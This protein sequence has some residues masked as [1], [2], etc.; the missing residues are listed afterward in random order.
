MRC[1]SALILL[2]LVA[3]NSPRDTRKQVAL[4][5]EIE[6]SLVLPA[7]ARPLQAYGR[8][9]AYSGSDEVTAVYLLPDAPMPK[10]WTCSI[11][12]KSGDRDCTRAEVE[13]MYRRDALNRARQTPA[14]VRRWHA[15]SSGLPVVND[16]G[17]MLVTVKYR[18]SA[19]RVEFATCNGFG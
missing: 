10:G 13:R 1:C 9:Y 16:G 5:D 15:N 8:N 2:L 3:A 12:D 11:S 17:C 7:G 19:H 4:M 14:G 6:R 18:I